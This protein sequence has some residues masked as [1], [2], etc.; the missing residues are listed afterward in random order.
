MKLDDF[1]EYLRGQNAPDDECWEW[2]WGVATTGYGR[3][4]VGGKLRGAHRVSYS[5]FWSWD[6][7]PVPR[8]LVVH[9]ICENKLCVNPG[10][11][12]VMTPKAHMR[13]HARTDFE[14]KTVCDYGHEM[15]PENTY[16]QPST[17]WRTCRACRRGL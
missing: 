13:H 1:L 17:G 3:I 9:H 15:T 4:R 11:L 2:T 5:W 6:D 10:H 16:V 7:K 14:R 12:M 8:S